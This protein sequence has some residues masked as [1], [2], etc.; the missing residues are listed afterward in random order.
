MECSGIMRRVNL[1]SES[2]I[3]NILLSSG[4]SD[5]TKKILSLLYKK[6]VNQKN[7]FL[8]VS[9]VPLIMRKFNLP[10]DKALK[11]KLSSIKKVS[12]SLSRKIK[13]QLSVPFSDI[14]Q[15]M[16]ISDNIWMSFVLNEANVDKFCD[17]LIQSL[18]RSINN[19]YEKNNNLFFDKKEFMLM[20]S[21]LI[22]AISLIYKHLYQENQH[23]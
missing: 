9:P 11:V 16:N 4:V 12:S 17:T 6:H 22:K 18:S 8:A 3:E 1:L 7:L 15:E 5:N 13:S 21:K 23:E 2:T 14:K 19:H 10:L 20:N